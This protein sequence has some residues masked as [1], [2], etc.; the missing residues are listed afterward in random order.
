LVR[1]WRMRLLPLRMPVLLNSVV[2]RVPILMMLLLV[3]VI[4]VVMKLLLLLRVSSRILIAVLIP[5]LRRMVLA[6]RGRPL[7]PRMVLMI[8]LLRRIR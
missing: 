7:M 1:P 4:G 6:V 3:A 5:I 2:P 8:M